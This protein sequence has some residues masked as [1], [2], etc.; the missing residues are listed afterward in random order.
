MKNSP[1]PGSTPHDR[2]LMRG[3]GVVRNR[4]QRYQHGIGTVSR[5]ESVYFRKQRLKN[6]SEHSDET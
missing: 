1:H 5:A 4:V 3:A 2:V 6:K